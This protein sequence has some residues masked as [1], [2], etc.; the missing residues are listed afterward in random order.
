MNTKLNVEC[1]SC[2]EYTAQCTYDEP[3]RYSWDEGF[4]CDYEFSH[5]CNVCGHKET[6]TFESRRGCCP[7]CGRPT[8]ELED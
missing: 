4:F 3:E 2:H 7:L 1:N 6:Q 8:P 5:E